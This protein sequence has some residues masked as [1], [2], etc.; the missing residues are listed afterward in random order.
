MALFACPRMPSQI[1]SSPPH[2]LAHSLPWPRT[3]SH[4][5]VHL[6]QFT[7]SY[8]T[9]LYGLAHS[10]TCLPTLSRSCTSLHILTCPSQALKWHHKYLHILPC[11]HKSLHTFQ[12]PHTLLHA[13]AW[14]CMSLTHPCLP[15]ECS[16]IHYHTLAQPQMYSQAL[17][18]PCTPSHALSGPYGT[19]AH[20][21]MFSS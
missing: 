2:A 6:A 5:L 1:L 17:T 16:C 19:L 15:F 10:C 21:Y 12:H 18:R 7:A 3:H 8:H 20:A 13:L 9:L 11:S 14:P 4:I